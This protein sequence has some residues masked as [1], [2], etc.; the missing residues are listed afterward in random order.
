M[1]WGQLCAPKNSCRVRG[2]QGSRRPLPPP[3]LPDTILAVPVMLPA[4]QGAQV[5]APLLGPKTGPLIPFL[6]VFRPCRHVSSPCKLPQIPGSV[7]HLVA[8]PGAHGH[9]PWV[10]PGT[11][12][13][14]GRGS[15]GTFEGLT[16]TQGWVPQHPGC[17]GE[18]GRVVS[19]LGG[20][21]VCS[22]PPNSSLRRQQGVGQRVVPVSSPGRTGSALCCSCPLPPAWGH[23]TG[24]RRV[25]GDHPEAP[26]PLQV[27]LIRATT[28]LPWDLAKVVVPAAA[29]A[30]PPAS[31]RGHRGGD[32]GDNT[33]F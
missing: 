4:C 16:P 26:R 33:K 17:H 24:H 9:V 10:R 32:K 23:P 22:H 8:P 13:G 18:G 7:W 14:S 1:L 19:R 25:L 11:R 27:A 2:L 21:R 20:S 29:L 30:V 5:G 3:L 15:A 28:R 12:R 6:Q 31:P